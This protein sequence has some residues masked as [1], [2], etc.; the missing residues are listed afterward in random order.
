MFLF[1][2]FSF[3]FWKTHSQKIR[4]A[5][6]SYVRCGYRMELSGVDSMGCRLLV[7]IDKRRGEMK[8]KMEMMTISLD[9]IIHFT[10]TG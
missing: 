6:F 9:G 1:S 2:F 5:H 8:V 4:F 10:S 3:L 7:G